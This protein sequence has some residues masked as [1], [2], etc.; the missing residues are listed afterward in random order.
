MA[1]SQPPLRRRRRGDV[2]LDDPIFPGESEGRQ[3]LR[4]AAALLGDIAWHEHPDYRAEQAL[5]SVLYMPVAGLD[6]GERAWL[7]AALHARYG[8][9][10]NSFDTLLR[11]S[12][13]TRWPRRASPAWRCAWPSPSRAGCRGCSA[14]S[15]LGLEGNALVLALGSDAARRYGESVQR[16]LDALGRALGKR[17]EVKRG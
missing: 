17:T 9:D 11:C 13:R 5:H 3:R 10:G 12:T 8:G 7:A 2:R 14:R 15:R 4:H 1:L 6:H 16:R